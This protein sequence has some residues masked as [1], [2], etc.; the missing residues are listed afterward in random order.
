MSNP[1]LTNVAFRRMFMRPMGA[2]K[3]GKVEARVDRILPHLVYL[4]NVV[5]DHP[6]MMLIGAFNLIPAPG[7][8]VTIDRRNFTMTVPEGNKVRRPVRIDALS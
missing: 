5:D 1:N 8:T 7:R 4:R 3:A 2:E 6:F